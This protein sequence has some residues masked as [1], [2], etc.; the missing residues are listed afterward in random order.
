MLLTESISISTAFFAYIGP[1]L[2]A[3]A[4]AA[5]IGLIAS[6]FLALFAVLFYPIKRLINKFRK[7]P[8]QATAN[9]EALVDDD[10]NA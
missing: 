2:G 10:D 5:A 9:A 8:S 7:T 6:F 1:G 4:I 3:G